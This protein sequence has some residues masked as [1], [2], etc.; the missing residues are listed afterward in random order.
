MNKTERKHTSIYI[1]HDIKYIKIFQLTMKPHEFW[2]Q[3]YT[4]HQSKGTQEAYKGHQSSPQGGY[5]FV[6][7]LLVEISLH[8]RE[9]ASIFK[10]TTKLHW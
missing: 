6:A 10:V 3:K 2:N 9:N 5:R 8:K 7:L 4:S 1:L